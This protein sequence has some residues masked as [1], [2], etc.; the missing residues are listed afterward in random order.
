[1]TLFLSGLNPVAD[2]SPVRNVYDSFKV[3][4]DKGEELRKHRSLVDDGRYEKTSYFGFVS[5][6][7]LRD[8]TK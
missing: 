3:K 2:K 4:N 8:C 6:T 1:M 5:N 7:G